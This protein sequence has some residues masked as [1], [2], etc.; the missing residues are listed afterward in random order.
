MEE[1]GLPEAVLTQ[2]ITVEA[3]AVTLTKLAFP[4]LVKT[5][6]VNVPVTP[7]NTI[8]AVV[9]DTVLVPLTSY[10]TV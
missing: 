9:D 6:V 3:T 7:E 8:V 2:L 1:I 4:V 5:V 10:V